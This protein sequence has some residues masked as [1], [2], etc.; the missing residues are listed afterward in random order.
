MERLLGRRQM[1]G[2]DDATPPVPLQD[3]RQGRPSRSPR[4]EP[5]TVPS[6]RPA[7]STWKARMS[8]TPTDE[9]GAGGRRSGRAAPRSERSS[10]ARNGGFRQRGPWPRTTCPATGPRAAFCLTAFP[11]GP[12]REVLA[13]LS[14]RHHVA[15]GAVAGLAD[16]AHRLSCSTAA[17][18]RI[19][20]VERHV[21]QAAF[22]RS[23]RTRG[24]CSRGSRWR[25][26]ARCR[27][28]SGPM[29]QLKRSANSCWV[30][31]SRLRIS[32]PVGSQRALGLG[33]RTAWSA[34]KKVT[35]RL[36]TGLANTQHVRRERTAALKER[37]A[38]ARPL[39]RAHVRSFRGSRSSIGTPGER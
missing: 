29:F 5:R 14:E 18:L 9:L 23:T 20:D 22:H 3:L 7:A 34:S 13:K 8:P 12:V 28:P 26:R 21:V 2:R 30:M 11:L 16:P 6:A 4:R 1:A 39:Q 15:L 10:E 24:A 36:R 27:G 35:G 25:R 32:L 17:L 31:R 37:H 33:A 38:V 19:D